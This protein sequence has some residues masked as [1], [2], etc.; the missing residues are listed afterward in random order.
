[1]WIRNSLDI[2]YLDRPILNYS[3]M[4]KT[5]NV[6]ETCRIIGVFGTGITDFQMVEIP[7]E[8]VL[9]HLPKNIIEKSDS[10][11]E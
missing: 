10:V 1:M 5:E 3:Y 4:A 11:E 6:E 7:V 8:K 2:N 9:G